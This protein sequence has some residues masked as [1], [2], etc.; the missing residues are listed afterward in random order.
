MKKSQIYSMILLMWLLLLSLATFTPA[1]TP[2]YVGIENNDTFTWD[3]T[4]DE[5]PLE[6]YIEDNAE[7]AGWS[8]SAIEDYLDTVEMKDDLVGVKIVILD[9]DDEE[10]SPWGEDGVR[11]IYNHY[12]MEED[13]EWDLENEDE[14][15]AV[16][17]FDEDI[18]GDD[19]NFATFYGDHFFEF[20]WFGEWDND[21]LEW[22]RW[23]FLEGENPWFI[24]TKVKWGDVVEELEDYYED[25]EDYDEVSIKA[26]KDANKLE[27][28]LDED[29]DDDI[30]E[31]SW[32]IQYDDN[33]VLMHYEWLYD[34]DPIVIVQTQESQIREFISEN[35][36]WIIIG[37]VGIVAVI[38]VIIVLIKRR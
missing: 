30:E 7:E 19:Y 34:G 16:W 23:Q 4:Y 27:I 10:K 26:D 1:A 29:E 36:I 14:T 9:V 15:F 13:D 2:G 18:Y 25:D 3:T 17:D 31:E 24:S 8:D 21:N 12:M 38:V 33:G 20:D 28:A 32:I 22:E 6:N 37:A 11:I 5:D 35:M